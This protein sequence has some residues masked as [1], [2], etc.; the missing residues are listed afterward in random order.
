[1]RAKEFSGNALVPEL[2]VTDW[3][4]SRWFY[5]EV[6][7][8]SVVYERPEEGFSYLAFGETQLMIDQIG[9]GRDL[10]DATR[11]LTPP[12]GRGM[13]L[14]IRT[15]GLEPILAAL[16]KSSIPLYL[17]VEEKWYRRDDHQIGQRQC[18]IA[19]PDGYLLR[20]F[21]DIGRSHDA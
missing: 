4:A 5:V 9:I 14:Q 21:E 15:D 16:Q 11:P 19:D 20:F 7:G 8:F 17:P 10:T 13:N 6:L 18:V 3:A 1:M 2:G 12:L